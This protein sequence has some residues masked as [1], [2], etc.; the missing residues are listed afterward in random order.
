VLKVIS[1]FPLEVTYLKEWAVQPSFLEYP[2]I[3]EKPTI[4]VA[5]LLHMHTNKEKIE[6]VVTSLTNKKAFQRKEEEPVYKCN[7]CE[8]T[9]PPEILD[10][11]ISTIKKFRGMDPRNNRKAAIAAQLK[12]R[13]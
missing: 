12:T 10:I 13:Y 5:Y 7:R 4:C 8:E 9:A 6:W 1:E 2:S 11:K 3:P